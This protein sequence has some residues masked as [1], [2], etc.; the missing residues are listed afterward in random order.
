LSPNQA[1]NLGFA[2]VDTKYTAFVDNDVIV[3][4]GWLEA[5]VTCA[6]ETGA[7]VVGPLT[8]QYEP[9]HE[10]IHCAGGECGA[11]EQ[12][13]GDIIRRAIVDKIYD[14]GKLVKD[15]R[16]NYQRR[17]TGVAEFHC[18][19]TS[20]SFLKRIGGFDEK[21]LNTKEHVDFCMSVKNRPRW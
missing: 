5:L 1:R 18:N 9:V 4:P 16:A 8:C 14:Q 6:E 7:A 10:I 11:A 15:M 13:R 17:E 3:T 2:L 12:K 20:S 19:L 21:L